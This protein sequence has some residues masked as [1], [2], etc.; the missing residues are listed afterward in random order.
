[1]MKINKQRI[2]YGIFTAITIVTGLAVRAR[3]QWFPGWFNDYAGDALYAVMMYFLVSLVTGTHP[4][5]KALIA[6]VLCY[7]IEFSQMF[8]FEWLN[9]IRQTTPGRL[10]LG[11]G[12]LYSDLAAYL[13]GVV[14]A[15]FIDILLQ[16][17]WLNLRDIDAK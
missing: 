15:F 8:Q 5:A 16:R 17:R 2:K 4:S 9:A 13:I 3:K 7:I 10:V 6:L 1:M 12:F 11:S 14:A